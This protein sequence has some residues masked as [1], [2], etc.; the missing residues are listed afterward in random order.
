M[1]TLNT[2][3]LLNPQGA[4]PN[5]AKTKTPTIRIFGEG[6]TAGKYR[7]QVDGIDLGQWTPNNLSQVDVTVAPPTPLSDGSHTFT[8]QELVPVSGN[9]TTP[10]TFKIDTGPPLAPV[11]TNAV[12]VG[13][14]ANGQYQIQVDGTAPADGRSIQLFNGTRMLG[15][16][17]VTNGRWHVATMQQSPGAYSLTAKVF[18][19]AGNVSL[20][21][22]AWPLTVGTVVPPQPTVP[23]APGL[24]PLTTTWT[25]VVPWFKPT[26]G[27]TPITGYKVY[28]NGQ[29]VAQVGAS[30]LSYT[31]V[32]LH[33]SYSY[34]VSA[35][36]AVGEGPQ[37][38]AEMP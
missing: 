37:S 10:Y 21:S 6:S 38:P 20:P 13:P 34:T 36:N 11:I 4:D 14:D 1:G 31:D 18:D 28:R 29:N 23:G 30:V 15:G 35:V 19:W 27:G 7:C 8:F 2:A 26:D 9:A 16:S 32:V 5:T 3:Y 33:G 17:I 12:A 22:A 24:A 25:V